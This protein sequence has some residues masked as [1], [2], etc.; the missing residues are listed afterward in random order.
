MIELS[1]IDK[2]FGDNHVL[3]DISLTLAEGTVTGLVES[4]QRAQ[5]RGLAGPG[6]PDHRGHRAGGHV[7]RD[8]AQHLQLAERLLHAT[9]RQQV[10]HLATYLS[11]LV[12][13]RI[14]ANDRTKQ[15]T[16]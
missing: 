6:W 15:I 14:C 1:H 4:V 9:N 16:Q 8:A 11:S 5:Y 13:S 2:T 7:E 10:A 3:K 12:S